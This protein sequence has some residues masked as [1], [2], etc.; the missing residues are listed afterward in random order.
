MNTGKL[1][2]PD[3][4]RRKSANLRT[5]LVF[6]SIAVVFFFGIIAARILGGPVI[7]VGVMGAIV[8]LFLVLA[9]GRNLRM[10]EGG[11]SQGPKGAS[12]SDCGG[13]P[14]DPVNAPPGARRPRK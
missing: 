8:L 13:R 9:I 2:T 7:G 1:G 12:P 10:S 5:A 14:S 4:A 3:E 6:A 11:E